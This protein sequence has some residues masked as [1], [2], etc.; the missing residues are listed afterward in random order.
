MR[1]YILVFVRGK[2]F[3]L[4]MKCYDR[5]QIS[6][7]PG[8]M[9]MV[10]R[11]ALVVLTLSSL[12]SV[13]AEPQ[14]L[15]ARG[16]ERIEIPGAVCGDGAPYSAFV[17]RGDPSKVAVTFMGGGA[18]WN[19]STCWGPTPLTW[20]HPLP[21]AYEILGGFFSSSAKE[22][23]IAGHTLI[24]LPYCTGDVHIGHHTAEYALGVRVH[25]VGRTNVERTLAFLAENGAVTPERV[26]DVVMYGYSAGALGALHHV[27][28]VDRMFPA[29]ERRTLIAD[30]PGLHFGPR[31][32]RK[33]SPRMIQDLGEAMEHVG[34]RLDT[35]QGLVAELVSALCQKHP[36]WEIGVLQGSRDIVMSALFGDITPE[37]HERLIFGPGGLWERT[38]RAGDSCSAWIPST[39]LHTFLVTTPTARTRVGEVTASDFSFMKVNRTSAASFRAP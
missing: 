31:F 24:H 26:R 36:G 11:L 28:L 12:S 38:S 15:G 19:L 37:E 25:H 22:S 18:C 33:F 27:D 29:A 39:Y 2:R 6:M 23:P 10:L 9:I 35:S 1:T 20:I 17:S 34:L 7:N 21:F 5:P 32:W 14:G 4:A 3:Q 30:S 8:G 13:A 16:W